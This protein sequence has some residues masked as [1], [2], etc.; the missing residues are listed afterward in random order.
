MYK[1]HTDILLTGDEGIKTISYQDGRIYSQEATSKVVQKEIETLGEIIQW[2]DQNCKKIGMAVFDGNNS[3]E[4][5]FIQSIENPI[6]ICRQGSASLMIDNFLFDKYAA[7][8][9]IETFN[10]MDFV[11]YLFIEKKITQSQYYEYTSKLIMM[12][13]SYIRTEPGLYIYLLNK[14]NCQI[15]EK[16]ERLFNNLKRDDLN[17]NIFYQM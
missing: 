5:N 10:V 8:H 3:K 9:N 13:Y 1:E 15:N 12:G 17:Q 7:E 14:N 11:R 6:L 2:I 16:V 4:K